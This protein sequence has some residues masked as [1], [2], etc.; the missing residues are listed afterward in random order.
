M[1]AESRNVV[2]LS[3]NTGK[4]TGFRVKNL[5]YSSLFMVILHR[6]LHN[7]DLKIMITSK[8]NT[9]GTG[10]TQLA[11]IL[12]HIISR[13]VEEIF[14]R[15]YDWN[16]AEH[17]FIDVYEYLERYENADNGDILI[18]DEIEYMADKRRSMSHD[19]VYFS[20]AWA[21]LRYKQVVTIGTA[22]GMFNLDKR[23]P[24]NTDIWINIQH[25][26][27]ANVYYMTV[28]DFTGEIIPK[29]FKQRGFAE[30]LRW[31]KID[32]W[33]DYKELTSEKE[34][35]GVP[36]MK[37][38]G[39]EI[40]EEDLQKTKQEMQREFATNLLRMKAAGKHSLDQEEMGQLANYS[41]QNISAIKK[42]EG[43]KI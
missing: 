32:H 16:A 9:T 27:L 43:I 17:S 40:T 38:E 41:Q 35:I 19:N 22:P 7:R 36:G 4:V 20:Q 42:Q 13:Y 5:Q 34:E 26:G 28:D 30:L 39:E 29:R 11:I 24:E 37:E 6:L 3:N 18:T 15:R 2:K 23:I 31:Q 14:D 33:E 1:S 8:G 12:A 10:K 25:P 21:M